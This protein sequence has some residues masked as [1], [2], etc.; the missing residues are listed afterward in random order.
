[1][2][3]TLLVSYVSP[4]GLAQESE[5][6]VPEPGSRQLLTL[7]PIPEL[8]DAI[9][10]VTYEQ[11]VDQLSVKGD[12]QEALGFDPTKARYFDAVCKAL[13]LTDEEIEIYRQRG[14]VSIDNGRFHTF[15]SA[16][17]DIYAS[18]L[19]VLVTTD[20]ILH[21]LH[22]SHEEILKE[23]ETTWFTWTL[24]EIL[25][26][27]HLKLAVEAAENG[28]PALADNYRDVDLYLTVARNLLNGAV[29]TRS[30]EGRR[31]PR[32][33]SDSSLIG[34]FLSQDE[35]VAALLAQIESLE[36]QNPDGGPSTA[37]YG[38][39]RFIDF[40]QF[41]P[42][43]HYTSSSV[44]QNYFRCMMWLGRADC[45]WNV[46][47]TDQS[48]AVVSRSKRELR[49]AALL[50]GLLHKT[51]NLKR[52]HEMDRVIAYLVGRSDSLNAF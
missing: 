38:G 49:D 14:L 31:P 13:Q 7:P 3:L 35:E 36:L 23:L 1:M 11:L 32:T 37:I 50:V 47:P 26:E 33:R 30:A 10:D 8:L 9:G 46:L 5:D 16:Y 34:S 15:S 17:F 44:L 4:A 18:D 25:A 40:S 20:S 42:R 28:E 51:G 19:P 39:S 41:Q 2:T 12:Y 22:K 52:L 21:A 6:A 24:D 43:G 29:R 27:L 45:G 48:L